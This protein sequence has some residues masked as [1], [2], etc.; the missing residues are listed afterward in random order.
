MRRTAAA[1]T[2]KREKANGER[3]REAARQLS[4]DCAALCNP[5]FLSSRF[6]GAAAAAAE[7]N[8]AASIAHSQRVTGLW[9]LGC[10]GMVFGAVVL[11]AADPCRSLPP[12]LCLTLI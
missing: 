10:S 3:A 12:F 5:R 1:A 8:M 9:M 11:G 4:C 6:L 7:A 2:R